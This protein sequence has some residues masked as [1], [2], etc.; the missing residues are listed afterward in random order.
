LSCLIAF[1]FHFLKTKQNKTKQKDKLGIN[2][3]GL[4]TFM[5]ASFA[6]GGFANAVLLGP[7]TKLL[8]GKLDRV[9]VNCLLSMSIAYALQGA[10]YHP[11]A[12]SLNILPDPN[13]DSPMAKFYA[14]PFIGL[15][16]L[17]SVFQFS[18]GTVI[19]AAT[20]SVVPDNS[21]GTLLGM[22]HS[23]FAAARILGPTMGVAAYTYAGIS[24]VSIAC[25]AGFFA[26]WGVWGIFSK[27]PKDEAS[28]KS[29]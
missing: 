6:F 18:L 1:I 15:T 2:E 28:K 26:V 3:A 14:Y 17:L 13:S 24:G 20:T 16:F 21:K 8:G 4:G 5:S 7:F 10:L 29:Q 22:E 25:T 27:S 19:T 11:S 12:A 9:I 23:L